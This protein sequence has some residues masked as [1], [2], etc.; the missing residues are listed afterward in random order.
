MS[1]TRSRCWP[2]TWPR[3]PRWRVPLDVSLALLP[4]E[5]EAI[6]RARRVDYAGISLRI[7][8]PDDLIIYKLVASRPKDLDDAEKLLSL[9]AEALDIE[10]IRR[11]VGE[12]AEILEDLER[13]KILEALLR[14]S[15]LSP[16]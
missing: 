9:H 15:G 1:G 7:P 8:S 13:P 11:V 16:S 14:R 5:L 12:F 10:R 4:F 2:T 3:A 6:Q